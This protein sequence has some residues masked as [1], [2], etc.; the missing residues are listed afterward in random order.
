MSEVDF[1]SSPLA[2]NA[3]SLMDAAELQLQQE[4]RSMFAV[5]TQAYLQTYISLVQR[6][7]PESWTAD[8]QELYRCIHTIKGGAV[9]VGS[10]GIL[11]A[12]TALEDLLSDL[13][14][15]QTAPPLADG[16]LPQMLLEAGE[17]LTGSLQIEGVGEAALYAVQP[18]VERLLALRQEIQQVYLPES[19][20]RT[21]LFHEFAEQ[22]FDL[23]VLDL[24][25]ALEELPPQGKVPTASLNIAKQT[26]QQLLQIGKDLEFEPGWIELLR[27]SKPLLTRLE[28]DFWQAQ[29]PIYLR[30]LKDCARK[31][32]KLSEVKG[33]KGK[34]K[35]GGAGDAGGEKPLATNSLQIAPQ[36]SVQIPVP[37]ERLDRSSQHLVETLLAARA[38]QGFYKNLQLQLV[39]LLTLAQDS[40]EYI[41]RLRQVQDEYAL[42]DNLQGKS[43]NSTT[44]PTLERY[45]QGYSIINRLLEISLRLSELG[46]ETATSARQTEDSLQVL[47][48]NVLSLQQTVEESRLIP[49]KMLGFR[50]K[51]ILRDLT[52]RYGKPAHLVVQGENIEL[53]AGTVQNLEPALLHLLRNAYDHGL[54]SPQERVAAGKPEQGTIALSLRRQ[55]KSYLLSLQ[56][57][58]RGI[59]AKLIAKIAQDKKLPLT[60]TDTAADLLAVLCQPGFSSKSQV[61]DV[62]GRGVGMDVVMAQVANLG[63][64]LSLDTSVG[65]GTTFHLQIPVPQLLVRCVLVQ[66]GDRI[67]AIPA[68]EIVTT[69]LWCNLSATP[70]PE[71]SV[72]TATTP[73]AYSWLIQQDGMSVPGLDLL[74]YWQKQTIPRTLSDT[75]VC[76]RIRSLSATSS[77]TQQDVWLLADDLLEQSDLLISRLPHPLIAPV[78]MMGVSLQNNGK[79]IP[80]LEPTTIAELLWTKP[81]QESQYNDSVSAASELT[82]YPHQPQQTVQDLLPSTRTILVVD[83]AA[84]VRRRIEAS[85]TAYGYVVHTCRDGLEAWNWLSSHPDPALIITD[86][87]MP[88]MD[89]FTLIDRCRQNSMNLPIVVVS[90]RLSEEWGKEARRLGATDYLTKGFTTPELINKVNSYVA[91]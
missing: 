16:Q 6:L 62:S 34:S 61:S 76:M 88:N 79:L 11:H 18:T 64:R 49:F 4:L 23:V 52:N 50:A 20:E 81:T 2:D 31:G 74:E 28:N 1:R 60:R 57:D 89:G 44:S 27:R 30:S 46:A 86:I 37:L 17:L 33:D 68:E 59:D 75:A 56:D 21:Q 69:T 90:S 73:R 82:S 54:E 66:A 53:D 42:L 58:G 14:Y 48:R 41:T 39:Q 32:G 35:A 22:G 51:G 12:S 67:F 26:L 10:D 55:G 25:M 71:P 84:L 38:S 3:L 7:Q 36:E 24:E 47:D 65:S 83:D 29:W 45:R 40:V 19:N 8:I 5:D 9:T 13:R 70:A 72:S 43:S 15:L 87:E 80:V 63:G 77:T 85:L 78:G 91:K